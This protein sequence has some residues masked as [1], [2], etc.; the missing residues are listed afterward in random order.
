MKKNNATPL[1][2]ETHKGETRLEALET[3][4]AQRMAEFFSLLGDA[5]RLRIL[6]LLAAEELCVCDLASALEM[7]ES[8][9][10]HQLRTLRGMRLVR[11]QKQGRRVFY[12]LLDHH[13]L[14]L[15]RAC[16]EHLEEPD[17]D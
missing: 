8:A 2:G 1:C 4:K 5:N 7:S 17:E 6:S 9:V 3:E 12:K 16:A 14:D 15:Y 10:S 11:Y 13:V